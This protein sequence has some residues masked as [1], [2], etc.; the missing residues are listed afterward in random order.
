[1]EMCFQF[2]YSFGNKN[3]QLFYD[4]TSFTDGD[5][6]RDYMWRGSLP[7]EIGSLTNYGKSSSGDL[8]FIVTDSNEFVTG[9]IPTQIG[10][11]TEVLYLDFYGLECNFTIPVSIVLFSYEFVEL[12]SSNH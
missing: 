8:S 12:Q 2:A 10:K 1:M 5:G 9:S 11:L 7:T 4:M 6:L 3:Q